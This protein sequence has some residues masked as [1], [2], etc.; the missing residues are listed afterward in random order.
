MTHRTTA[1]TDSNDQIRETVRATYGRIATEGASCC[2]PSGCGPV[3]PDVSLAL[4]YDADALAALP[5]GANLGLGC[6]NPHAIAALRRGETVL[7]LGSGGGIDCLLAARAVGP[8]G[9]VIG[10][11]MTPEMITRAR[12]NAAAAGAANVEIR[13]GEIEALPVGDGTV[14]VVISN[15]VVNLSPDKPRVF[16]EVMRVLRPG[17]RVAISDIVATGELPDALRDDVAALTGCVAGAAPVAELV[18][19]LEGAGFADVSVTVDEAS[20]EVVESWFPGRGLGALVASARIEAIRPR[21]GACC[22]PAATS[23]AA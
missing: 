22:G 18:A 15:C 3:T 13:L 11:D 12:A 10:V 9:H 5:E 7:D 23:G 1:S 4:G 19:M 21:A 16:R 2:A 6:G 20:R 14:D 17:G 8:E